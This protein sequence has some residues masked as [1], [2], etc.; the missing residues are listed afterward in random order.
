M[1]VLESK[2]LLTGDGSKDFAVQWEPGLFG[3][4]VTLRHKGAQEALDTS[5]LP[6]YR[7]Y[8]PR[9]PRAGS[10]A[11]LVFTPYY[12]FLNRGPSALQVWVEA[13]GR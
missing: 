12:T 2:L 5:G 11:G 8:N 6:L 1:N 4:I 13:V 7:R 9:E 10:R 3:G